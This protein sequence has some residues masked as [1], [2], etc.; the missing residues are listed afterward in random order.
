MP[1]Y[2]F[3]V[4]EESKWAVSFEADD[5]EHAKELIQEAEEDM[6][7][8]WLPGMERYFRKGDEIWDMETLQEMKEEN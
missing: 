2:A 3:N 5:L 4:W 6:D 8:E 7:L 1:R